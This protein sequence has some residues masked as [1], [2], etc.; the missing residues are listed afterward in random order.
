MKKSPLFTILILTIGLLFV[1]TQAFASPAGIGPKKTPGPQGTPDSQHTPGPRNTP[2]A[3]ATTE[4][5]QH[6]KGKH[7]NFRGTIAAVSSSSLTLNL[8][9][10]SSATFDLTADTRIQIPGGNGGGLQVGMQAMVQAFDNGGSNLVAR[11]VVVIPGQPIR[12]H[13]VG[14]VTAYT[15]GVS[16]TIQAS[17]GGTYTFGLTSNTQIL[18]SNLA[19]QLAVGS[20]VTIIAPRDPSSSGWTAVGIVIH[21]AGSGEGSMPPTATLTATATATA[22]LPATATAT[23]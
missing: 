23:P 16:I 8:R 7:Q 15:P 11:A 12:V 13:R 20:R 18:P 14:W 19:S 3:Q 1:T 5:L 6:G 2:G 9:G 21:P 4:A 10:G 17:D 22:T